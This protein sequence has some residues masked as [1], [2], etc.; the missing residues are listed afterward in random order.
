MLTSHCQTFN[1]VQVLKVAGDLTIRMPDSAA[2]LTVA[3]CVFPGNH[4]GVVFDDALQ[5]CLLAQNT[6]R[7]CGAPGRLSL[8]PW[9]LGR[10]DVW[11]PVPAFA[12]G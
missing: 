10:P 12:S 3:L 1:H 9:S 7:V 4:R 5:G 8:R 6:G 11:V 2:V